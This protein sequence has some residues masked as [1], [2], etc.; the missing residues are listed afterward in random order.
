M[1]DYLSGGRVQG[2]STLT[3]APPATSWKE[4]DRTKIGSAG[5]SINVTGLSAKDNIMILGHV[6]DDGTDNPACGVQ[7]NG[8][9]T[10]NKYYQRYRS[11]FG[12]VTSNASPSNY[13][14]LSDG[15]G[16]GTSAFITAN[17][18]NGGSSSDEKLGIFKCVADRSGTSTTDNPNVW[19]NAGQ[20]TDS[21][22]ITSVNVY[23]TNTGNFNTDSEV[24]VLGC[25]NDES[26]S[27]TN[28]WQELASVE[29]ADTTTS[30][31]TGDF[32]AKKYLWLQFYAEYSGDSYSEMVF[33][34]N[35]TG[36]QY[37]QK[38]WYGSGS[39]SD[40]DSRNNF[41]FADSSVH[42]ALYVDV[43]IVNQLDKPKFI[44]ST[45]TVTSSTGTGHTGFYKQVGK[46]IKTD[47]QINNITISKG[48]SGGYTYKNV[49]VWG[50]N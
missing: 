23:N 25:D 6:L 40:N 9:T 32:T 21:N 17:I 12:T 45:N 10:G 41:T 44:M 48:G 30:I 37:C 47:Q 1:V 18:T 39:G 11:D 35:T 22:P 29:E 19:E 2:S 26:D 20:F 46:W 13:I 3:S 36:S 8:V 27:G 15:L 38:S 28:F 16:A 14:Y 34:S 33:N 5:D 49:K 50:G 24:I 42:H 7:F 31:T 43:M 4:L